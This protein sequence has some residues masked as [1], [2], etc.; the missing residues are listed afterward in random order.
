VA[1]KI[2]RALMKNPSRVSGGELT[3]EE[4]KASPRRIYDEKIKQEKEIFQKR[5]Y[6]Y[7]APFNYP[8]IVVELGRS[9]VGAEYN[10]DGVELDIPPYGAITL[11][12]NEPIIQVEV[13]GSACTPPG[14]VILHGEP[15]EWKY[16]RTAV[17]MKIDGLWGLHLYHTLWYNG[18]DEG[19]RSAGLSSACFS[20][21][22]CK[23]ITLMGG[24]Q[25]DPEAE[26]DFHDGHYCFRIIRV[27]V[28]QSIQK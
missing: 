17:K 24:S 6:Q 28:K 25:T 18:V 12:E 3:E 23:K 2:E 13:I 14:Y 22:E 7:W 9:G 21:P 5:T 16:P 10:M 1:K 15:I 4:K 8:N 26:L 19:F 11:I 20:I 27:T